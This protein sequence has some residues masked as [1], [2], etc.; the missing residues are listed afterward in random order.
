MEFRNLCLEFGNFGVV[1]DAV[2]AVVSC[3][4]GCCGEEA[5]AV[6]CHEIVVEEGKGLG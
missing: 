6:R 2:G 5:V 1:F 3:G 4:R